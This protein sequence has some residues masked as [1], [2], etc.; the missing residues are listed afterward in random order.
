VRWI[1]TTGL[2]I[3]GG[4]EGIVRVVDGAGATV[5]AENTAAAKSGEIYCVA[6]HPSQRLFASGHQDGRVHIWSWDG[7]AI[8]L[9]RSLPVVRWR[10]LGAAFSP[11]GSLLATTGPQAGAVLWD[12]ATW[13]RV[14][15]LPSA[16][17][18]WPILFTPDGGRIVAGGFQGGIDIWD[19][20]SRRPVGSFTG[21]ER[22]IA[23]MSISADGKTLVT[24]SDDGLVKVWTLDPLREM[25]V[26]PTRHN[27]A[28]AV[29]LDPLRP[30]IAAACQ[31]DATVVWD[32]ARVDG[33]IEGNRE[34]QRA[35]V[36]P[37]AKD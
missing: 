18:C 27:E 6:L 9:V 25:A 7:Q 15:D 21:H 3:A 20:R 29:G 4:E 31:A 16:Q 5:I 19:A 11:D 37:A 2:L 35:L 8:A 24:G 13:E 26:F 14:A 33:W 30:R 23:G 17:T 12:T 34:Y 1:G 32:F 28:V 22:L 36:G 10:A